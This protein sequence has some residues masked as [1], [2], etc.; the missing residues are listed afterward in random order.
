MRPLHPLALA[1]RLGI[2]VPL[3]V[4][5]PQLGKKRGRF[6]ISHNFAP[7]CKNI[8]SD[9]CPDLSASWS[10]FMCDK[11]WFSKLPLYKLQCLQLLYLGNTA[12][13]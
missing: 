6:L 7:Y 1:W 3:V 11:G 13:G 4:F 9:L 2:Y 5:I 8:Q 10:I 12:I